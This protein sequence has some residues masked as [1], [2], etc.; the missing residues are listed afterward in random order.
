MAGV[1][2]VD[3]TLF[4]DTI[5]ENSLVEI[6]QEIFLA[7]TIL[8][9]LKCAY[10]HPDKR[11]FCILVAGFFACML[12]RELDALFDM[13]IHGFWVVPALI[14]TGL[15]LRAA[16][17]YKNS[18]LRPMAS[19]FNSRAYISIALGLCTVLVFS[20][21]IGMNLLWQD[22]MGAHY[23]RAVKNMVEE[24]TELIGYFMI[25]CGALAYGYQQR[26]IRQKIHQTQECFLDTTTCT[27]NY[28]QINETSPKETKQGCN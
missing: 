12:I 19:F 3:I 15:S 2:I 20:R 6:T 11:G 14:M 10:L 13:I 28:R 4:K 21:L 26:Q 25:S 7:A 23:I 17:Y 8:I 27:T 1:I 9:F 18:V 16:F 22:L 5:S 24:G